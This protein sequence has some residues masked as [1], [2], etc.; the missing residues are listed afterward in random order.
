[1]TARF[2]A[3]LALSV[4]VLFL[5]MGHMI[6]GASLEEWVPVGWNRIAQ[7]ILATPVV[8]WC[9]AFAFGR[10]AASLRTRN[11]NMWTLIGLGTGAA[12]AF[13][14]A[15]LLFGDS[16]P[17]TLKE[18]GHVPLYF[19]SAAVILTLVLLGQM[20]EAGARRRTGDALRRLM[21]QSAKT[22]RRIRDGREEEIPVEDVEVGDVL[23][24]KPGEKVPVDGTVTEGRSRVDESM[25][26]GESEP[27]AKAEGDDVTGGTV[28]KTGA[29]RMEARRVGADTVLSRIVD[30]VARAQRSRAPIQGVADRVAA[31]FVPSVVGVAVVAFISWAIWGP[32]PRFSHALINAVAVLIIACPC[33]LGLATPVSIMVGVGRGAGIGILV[34]DAEALEMLERVDTLM[35]DKTG[36]L[37]EGRPRVTD[38]VPDD[39]T[40]E[41]ILL[42]TAAAIEHESEHPL[43]AAILEA[44]R[45]RDIGGEQVRDFDS[46]PGAG[47]RGEIAG[48]AVLIG[49]P[50][51]LR[52]GGVEGLDVLVERTDGLQGEGKTVV[53]VARGGRALGLI[54]VT[55]PARDGAKESLDQLREL[56]LRIVMLTGDNEGTARTVARRLGIDDFRAEIDPEAKHDV[57][58]AAREKGHRVAMAGDGI[59]DAP[60]LA[61]ADVGI[62]M[63]SGTDVAIESAGLTLVKSDLRAVVRA[64]RLS[65]ATMRNIR[66]NLFFAFAYNALGVPLAAGILYPFTGLLLSPMIA[67]AAMSFSS[68][69]VIGNALRLRRLSL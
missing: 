38:I 63:G 37:T 23:R 45:E 15:A 9:G 19:E 67:A 22:A 1:M 64:I 47:A 40:D 4:P 32:E 25:I 34:R 14:V 60:A 11:P 2:W 39:G 12:Y 30:M 65:R 42:R 51:F 56:G 27:V 20:L 10:F 6:P 68:V 33:A 59:N 8:F 53:W 36:T 17:D 24:V 61:A 16:F 62:A 49:K 50:D 18:G 13:S 26:T 66:Q 29:F 43:G 58:R 31:I 5:A 55:D 35:V 48:E 54:A 46:V 52:D 21:D 41:A 7:F 28:N 57:V 44:A 69:S 3:A